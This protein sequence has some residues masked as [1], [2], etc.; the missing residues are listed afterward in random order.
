L[1]HDLVGVAVARKLSLTGRAVGAEEALSLRLVSS[2]VPP[3]NLDRKARTLAERIAGSPRDV[4]VRTR[5]KF[6]RLS[7][8]AIRGTLDL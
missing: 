3:E 4:L 6:M 2:V 7:N 8:S 1:L 5:A